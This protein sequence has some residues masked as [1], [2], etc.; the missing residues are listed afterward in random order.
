M[1]ITLSPNLKAALQEHAR[2]QGIAPEELALNVLK[3][4]FLDPAPPVPRDAWER[5]LF[6]AARDWGISLPDT[7]LTS[8]ELYD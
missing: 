3:E 7:T 2:R 8:E 4:R 1:V 6:E 5:G